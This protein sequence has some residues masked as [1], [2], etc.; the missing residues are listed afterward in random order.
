MVSYVLITWFTLRTTQSVQ[1][2][3]QWSQ[4][5]FCC[6]HAQSK[7]HGFPNRPENSRGF[8]EGD[9][10]LAYTF[11]SLKINRY[12]SFF[13]S[14]SSLDTFLSL[15]EVQAIEDANYRKGIWKVNIIIGHLI[16]KLF[17]DNPESPERCVSE[18]RGR[19][20]LNPDKIGAIK[21]V[22][23]IIS[24]HYTFIYIHF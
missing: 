17:S 5:E 1:N 22:F 15:E 21:G 10:Y 9:H 14:Q 6:S 11:F 18:E 2:Q 13:L 23:I 8:H 12:W 7:R 24:A 19:K 4:P 3:I 20:R 16:M